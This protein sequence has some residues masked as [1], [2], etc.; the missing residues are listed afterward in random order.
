M[1]ACEACRWQG[2]SF[3][4]AIWSLYTNPPPPQP[5]PPRVLTESWGVVRSGAGSSRP[6]PPPPGGWHR[7]VFDPHKAA[8]SLPTL[9]VRHQCLRSA[10]RSHKTHAT[11]HRCTS[12]WIRRGC[13]KKCVRHVGPTKFVS[14][15]TGHSIQQL[16]TTAAVARTFRSHLVA[17]HPPTNPASGGYASKHTPTREP[18]PPPGTAH[19]PTPTP[20]LA[21][22]PP[23]EHHKTAHAHARTPLQVLNG[24]VVSVLPATVGTAL[25]T[26]PPSQLERKACPNNA[27]FATNLTACQ[28]HPE[29]L[30]AAEMT[31]HGGSPSRRRD[32]VNT[33]TC[34]KGVGRDASELEGALSRVLAQAQVEA[35]GG[36]GGGCVG[37]QGHGTIG[38]GLSLRLCPLTLSVRPL[39]DPPAPGL[40]HVAPFLCALDCI[41]SV[42]GPVSSA[43][44]V[45]TPCA[46]RSSTG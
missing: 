35:G 19:R 28:N 30:L 24:Q 7:R 40:P 44:P 26:L 11:G 22:V 6:P 27:L 3:Q 42:A 33:A 39:M 10:R 20:A 25:M 43:P 31:G 45:L 12:L 23:R 13:T 1:A 32:W 15:S 46:I 14:R 34:T 4:L 2:G 38:Q 21:A 17:L 5:P 36:G 16:R 18:T 41:L 8:Y 37:M 29:L 9:E